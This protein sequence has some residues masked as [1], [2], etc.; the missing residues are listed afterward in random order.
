MSG[1]LLKKR[2]KKMQGWAKRWFELTP[3]GVLSYSFRKDSVKR[4]S[5]Q[6][7]FA[8]VSVSP[9][10][11]IIH[12]DSG[13]T[14]FHLRALSTE[15]FDQW[16]EGI[17]GKRA[18]KVVWEEHDDGTRS[19]ISLSSEIDHNQVIVKALNDLDVELKSLSTLLVSN[20]QE[21]VVASSSSASMVSTPPPPLLHHSSGSSIKLRFPFKR[22][23]SY[24]STLDAYHQSPSTVV[25]LEKV[26]RSIKLMTDYREKLANAYDQSVNTLLDVP[27]SRTGTGLMSHRSVSS[28]Y[29]YGG[30]SDTFFDAEDFSISG[31]EDVVAGDSEDEVVGFFFFTKWGF[32]LKLDSSH[33]EE[34]V[35]KDLISRRTRLPHTVAVKKLSIIS[36]L[37]KF[38]GKDLSSIPLPIM[39]NEPLNLL[40]RLCEELEYS[41]L[42]DHAATQAS[43]MDRLM[44]VTA[45]AVS[46]YASTHYRL[47][48]KPFNP[49][50]GETYECVRTDKGFTFISEKVSH[51][52]NTMA[53][54]A[55]S[56]NFE[57]RQ[58]FAGDI[59]F[60]GQ[61]MDLYTKGQGHVTLTG[62][63]DQFTYT[64]PMSSSKNLVTG[65]K[66][67]EHVGEMRVNNHETGEYAIVNFKESKSGSGFFSSGGGN[68]MD[69]NKIEAKFF[70][71]RG[72]LIK[73]VEGKWNDTLSEVSG[74]DQYTVIWRAKAPDVQEP[75]EYYGFTQFA[76]EL[77]EIT[78]LEESKLPATDTRYRKDQR[79][80]EDGFVSE[81]EV[82][83]TRVEQ[84]QRERRAQGESAVPMWFEMKEDKYHPDGESWQ[85]KGGYWEARSSG[86]WPQ[87]VNLW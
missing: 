30:I 54:H 17:R 40:Q 52:P 79:L 76:M 78:A 58:S 26:S 31:E 33:G 62:H 29:S 13:T 61:S 41:E 43:S 75:Q 45:F 59:K 55:S 42:L 37:R 57:F 48:R 66:Y 9:K 35:S 21:L 12:L 83:K 80:F 86:Q 51:V 7:L 5:I 24:S 50:L 64:K 71:C 46:G 34:N 65:T 23:A 28:F 70:D 72:S 2:R 81:A 82:E 44:Y 4:G 25:V 14:T 56:R 22:G 68:I 63:Q 10:Q 77:N 32:F 38:I 1:W 85:Y 53:C 36:L 6:T 27:G 87:T 18:K 19:A 74:P 39:L 49:L 73:E 11:R 84:F 15:Q 67:I 8:T 69:R 3:D 20:N 16:L 60:W 47:G